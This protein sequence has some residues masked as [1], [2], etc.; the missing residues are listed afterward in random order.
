MQTQEGLKLSIGSGSPLERPVSVSG[1]MDPSGGL[2]RY[3]PKLQVDLSADE[4]I[5]L[6]GS[7]ELGN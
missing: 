3:C 6:H 7:L 5:E 1:M 2:G 4:R